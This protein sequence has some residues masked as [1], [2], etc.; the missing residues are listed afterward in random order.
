[1]AWP[2]Q[3]DLLL[4][5]CVLFVSSRFN[6]RRQ[7]LMASL[8]SYTV[9]KPQNRNKTTDL[10]I[11]SDLNILNPVSQTRVNDE[12]LHVCFSTGLQ[13]SPSTHYEPTAV[14]PQFF[15]SSHLPLT[16]LSVFFLPAIRGWIHHD[17]TSRVCSNENLASQN[18]HQPNSSARASHLSSLSVPKL[19]RHMSLY[20]SPF[21]RLLTELGHAS[22]WPLSVTVRVR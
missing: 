18:D 8:S 20:V 13:Q 11:T 16:G 1:M 14:K 9:T 19:D 2:V 7:S 4:R 17:K 6:L 5:R 21:S 12:L 15:L 3:L 22:I 10:S